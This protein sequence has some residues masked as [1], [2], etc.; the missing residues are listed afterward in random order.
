MRILQAM[1][2]LLQGV[3]HLQRAYGHLKM[4]AQLLGIPDYFLDE[5]EEDVPDL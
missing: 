4:T 3:G 5:I 2:H 1:L